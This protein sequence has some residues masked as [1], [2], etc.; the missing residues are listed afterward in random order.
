MHF[1]QNIRDSKWIS[2]KWIGGSLLILLGSLLILLAVY[3]VTWLLRRGPALLLGFIIILAFFLAAPKAKW[4]YDLAELSRSIE[5]KGTR[6]EYR[7]GPQTRTMY[8]PYDNFRWIYGKK[9][10][11]IYVENGTRVVVYNRDGAIIKSKNDSIEVGLDYI[12]H[13]GWMGIWSRVTS[14]YADG[15]GVIHE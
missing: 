4:D 9:P 3:V 14:V 7:Y 8:D 5:Y 13:K 10:S 2:L 15:K 12:H 6:F 11:E 1:F